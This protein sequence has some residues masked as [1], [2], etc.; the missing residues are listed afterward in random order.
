M[1][2]ILFSNSEIIGLYEKESLVKQNAFVAV[3]R[4]MK[5][6]LI[7]QEIYFQIK[8]RLFQDFNIPI[9]D[10]QQIIQIANLYIDYRKIEENGLEALE[11]VLKHIE[12]RFNYLEDIM[13]K[14]SRITVTFPGNSAVDNKMMTVEI[15]DR[16]R[17][18]DVDN[19]V[20][21]RNEL[22]KFLVKKIQKMELDFEGRVMFGIVSD[23]QASL[24]SYQVWP[25]DQENWNLP[26]NSK[27]PGEGLA[28]C[29]QYQVPGVYGIVTD[30]MFGYDKL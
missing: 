29:F 18:L 20:F 4:M 30:P 27:I 6:G 26:E 25:A 16:W 12:E 11:K 10:L 21:I 8:Q 7:T 22:F 19:Y 2:Y 5:K 14:D 17:A 28:V 23:T 24:M 15:E 3:Y 9:K 1:V 13:S